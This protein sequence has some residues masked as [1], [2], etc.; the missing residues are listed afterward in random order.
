MPAENRTIHL[1]L[2][3]E[4]F[5]RRTFLPGDLLSFS[6]LVFGE[7]AC[8]HV[9]QIVTA[10]KLML[11]GDLGGCLDCFALA[12]AAEASSGDVFFDEDGYHAVQGSYVWQNDSDAKYPVQK[13]SLSFD[14]DFPLYL[15]YVET[16]TVATLPFDVFMKYCLDRIEGIC[17]DYSDGQQRIENRETLL[18]DARHIQTVQTALRLVD[19]YPPKVKG[20]VACLAGEVEYAGALSDFLPYID[21]CSLI[22][23]GSETA[24]LGFGKFSYK[25]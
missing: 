2:K 6:M 12:S 8:A 7:Y 14:E 9:R 11:Q 16:A 19:R 18:C 23:V 13:I 4:P 24:R 17:R 3:N 22:H 15:R 21:I 10:V 5:D 25:I 20:P 1:S